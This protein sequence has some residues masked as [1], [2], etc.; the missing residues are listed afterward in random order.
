MEVGTNFE[1]LNWIDNKG[2]KTKFTL[3]FVKHIILTDIS[4]KTRGPL[5]ENE[6]IEDK[7]WKQLRTKTLGPLKDKGVLGEEKVKRLHTYYDVV[8]TRR[9]TGRL[10]NGEKGIHF[11]RTHYF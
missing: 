1:E 2:K 4:Y 9:D 10:S 5:K 7:K 3:P 6:M 11:L 8:S